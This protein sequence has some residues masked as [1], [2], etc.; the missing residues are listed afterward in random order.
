MED[1]PFPK[2]LRLKK[3]I[4]KDS[5]TVFFFVNLRLAHFS[6]VLLTNIDSSISFFS[7]LIIITTKILSKEFLQ[8]FFNFLSFFSSLS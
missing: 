4:D 2:E 8:T 3:K 7:R 1:D 6:E 5:A